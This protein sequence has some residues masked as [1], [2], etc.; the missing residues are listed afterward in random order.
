MTRIVLTIQLLCGLLSE[1]M[2][3]MMPTVDE[4]RLEAFLDGLTLGRLE[5]ARY[6][7]DFP[8]APS[9]DD[10]YATGWPYSDED[11]RA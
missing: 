2:V 11:E 8:V 6:E 1:R 9:P 3:L 5:R 4:Q 7:A 10:E